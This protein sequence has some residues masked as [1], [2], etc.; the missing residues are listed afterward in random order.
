MRLKSYKNVLSVDSISEESIQKAVIEWVRLDPLL[1]KVIFHIPN[2]GKRTW[3][4]GRLLKLLGMRAGV[5][6]LFIALSRH[7]FHGAWIELKSSKG[8]LTPAQK[9]FMRDMSG[10]GYYV[11]TCYSIDE[12]IG[13]IK[14]YAF[15][16]N[17]SERVA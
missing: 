3:H 4:F 12:A 17:L 1:R 5:S 9:E 10:Q 8:V 7:G 2:E 14:S 16:N 13:V 6:D 15:G 11:T